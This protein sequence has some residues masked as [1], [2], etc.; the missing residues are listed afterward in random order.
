[1]AK[2]LINPN[3]RSLISIGLVGCDNYSTTSLADSTN[4]VLGQLLE[5]GIHRYSIGSHYEFILLGITCYSSFYPT[6]IFTNKT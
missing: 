2:D 1:M 6:N 5:K 3:G 4:V